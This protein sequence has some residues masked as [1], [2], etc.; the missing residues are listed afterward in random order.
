M[1]TRHLGWLLGAAGVALVAFSV[2]ADA[3]GVGGPED[4]TFGWEQKAGVLVGCGVLAALV[5]RA[6]QRHQLTG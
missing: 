1:G 4:Y 3:L 2:L 5:A 6:R